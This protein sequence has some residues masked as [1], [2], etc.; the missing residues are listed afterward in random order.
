MLRFIPVS[1]TPIKGGLD[2]DDAG[3]GLLGDEGHGSHL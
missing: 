1:S 2:I 3:A